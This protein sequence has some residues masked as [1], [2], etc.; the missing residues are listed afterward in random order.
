MHLRG[1]S[2]Q[3]VN[4]I[5]SVTSR[6]KRLSFVN[7]AM[8]LQDILSLAERLRL[9]KKGCAPRETKNM[10]KEMKLCNGHFHAYLKS[11]IFTT[12]SLIVRSPDLICITELKTR[13]ATCVGILFSVLSRGYDFKSHAT[14]YFKLYSNL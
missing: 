6:V 8:K 1:T 9:L 5:Y 3:N 12:K 2:C 14:D 10:I 7:M 4:W 13:G 11:P